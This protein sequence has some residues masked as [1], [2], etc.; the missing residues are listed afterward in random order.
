LLFHHPDNHLVARRIAG[1]AAMIRRLAVLILMSSTLPTFTCGAEPSDDD[2]RKKPITTDRGELGKLLTLWYKEGTAAGNVGDW[3]DNRDG[4]HSP[5]DLRP[6]PQLRKVIYTEADVKAR[7]HWALQPRI[8]P[9]VVFGNSSTSAPPQM[10]GSNVRTYYCSPD[11]LDILASQYTHNNLYIYPEHRDHDPGHNGVGDGYGD[12]YPTNTPYLLTSQGSSG[13]DQPFMR[14]LPFTLA[15]F[16]PEV[17]KKLV[18]T[19]LLMPTVQMI[20]RSM[21]RHLSSPKEYLTGMAHPTVFEGSWVDPLAM[22]KRAHEITAD[23]IPPLV[24]LLVVEERKAVAGKDFFEPPGY[25]EQHSDTVSVIARIWRG[26]DRQRRL[27]VSAEESLDVNKKPLTFTWVVLRGDEKRIQIRPRNKAGSVAEIIV[28]YHER[29]P[30]APGSPMESNRVDI[31]V[32]AHNGSYYSA[33]GF[34][35]FYSLDCE[36]RT[37]DEKGRPVEIGYGMGETEWK[38]TDPGSLFTALAADGLAARL[39][40]LSAEQ[41]STLSKCAEEYRPLQAAA[42]KARKERQAREK[43]RNTTVMEVRAAETRLAE[44]RKAKKDSEEVKKAERALADIR[45]TEK[46]AEREYQATARAVSEAEA[47]V[48]KLLDGNLP[49]LKTSPRAFALGLLR[50]KARMPE[51]WNDHVEG[52]CEQYDRPP[53]APRRGRIDEAR[54][55]LLHLGIASDGPRRKLVLRP[56]RTGAGPIADRLTVY[57]KALLEH[58]NA[59]VLAELVVPGAVQVIFHTNFVDQRLTTPKRWRDVFHHDGNRLVGWTRYHDGKVSEFTDDGLLVLKKDDRGRPIKARSVVYRQAP[60]VGRSW[61]NTQPLR[62]VGGTEV[63]TFEYD[64]ERRKEKGREKV[65]EER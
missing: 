13:S 29:R 61:V 6:Y 23:R 24:K 8:L 32:F 48:N 18:E 19:G 1:E 38:L 30:I 15:A 56:A 25:T 45:E 60:Q 31:G 51:L 43:D 55:R 44:L 64:G 12:L 21:N 54:R 49:A 22:V 57:E 65:L 37:Y 52:L 27:L 2:L 39:F 5:L 59:V 33:P 16:R 46:K 53:S 28:A 4:E 7:R 62:F 9:H 11:G 58:F 47:K 35:T 3:Y 50:Q 14:A 17:K 41:R 26:R 20:L 42:E 63:V 36:G 10:S 40:A 34:I